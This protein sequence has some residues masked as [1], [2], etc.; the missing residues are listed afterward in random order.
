KIYLMMIE[1][2]VGYVEDKEEKEQ[3]EQA[4]K[5]ALLEE[6][7]DQQERRRI[8]EEVRL[9]NERSP[10]YFEPPY[11]QQGEYVVNPR[12]IGQRE[13]KERIFNKGRDNFI[14]DPKTG[15]LVMVVE[16]DLL[17]K[18]KDVIK[19][20][21]VPKKMV[22]IEVLLF[23]RIMK[24][25]N[26]HGLNMLKLADAAKDKHISEGAWAGGL[27]NCLAN[28]APLCT[29]RGILEF[30]FSRE[31]S[32]MLPAFD[33]AYKFLMSQE[34]LYLNASPSVVTLNQTEASIT[35]NDERSV[36]VGRN[37]TDSNTVTA[38]DAFQRAQYGININV[39]PTIHMADEEDSFGDPT[40]YVT[41]VSKINFDTFPAGQEDSDQPRVN[42]RE[43]K[44]EVRI[45][46]GQ[47]VIIGGLRR[48]DMRDAVGK[49][50]FLGEIPGLGKL[51]SATALEDTDTEMIIF[52]TPKIISEPKEDFAK[53]RFEEL[54][55]RPG[56]LPAFLYK[57]NH[58]LDCEKNRLFQGWMTMLFGRKQPRYI[59]EEGE[60][61]GR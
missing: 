37:I 43:I 31:K 21:D 3:R 5:E 1:G 57:L 44:N 50:P 32:N 29:G 42:R 61:D 18:L 51:F 27:G 34:D 6:K 38:Q 35:I 24:R 55:R 47:S 11:Y 25:K 2:R 8:S 7:R 19:K 22:Q 14:V 60:Y 10:R 56:D 13:R 23:E 28:A 12:P 53:L 15:A 41:L 26:E 52:I 39:V 17:P 4:K 45:P 49:I 20:L 9:F 54:C 30:F 46:D 48:K 33:L 58:A 36:R 16:T 59:C 40:N